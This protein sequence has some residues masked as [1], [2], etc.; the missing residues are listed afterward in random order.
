MGPTEWVVMVVRQCGPSGVG[1]GLVWWLIKWVEIVEQWRSEWFMNFDWCCLWVLIDS[2]DRHGSW[3]LIKQ[4]RSGGLWLGWFGGGAVM[5]WWWCDDWWWWSHG[6]GGC[7]HAPNPIPGFMAM[8]D[9]L[10]SSLNL[11]LTRTN[12]TFTNL[13]QKLLSFFLSLFSYLN[14]IIFHLTFKASTLY[15][16][17]NINHQ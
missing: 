10:I 13:L 9:M 7:C 3:V 6:G 1:R 11:I 12:L 5:V 17:N 15:S 14:D 16:K 4:W 8:T 2:G